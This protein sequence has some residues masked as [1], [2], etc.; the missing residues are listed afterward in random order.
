MLTKKLPLEC[1]ERTD[2]LL[3][4]IIDLKLNFNFEAEKEE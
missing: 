1:E 4:E 2:E 3:A